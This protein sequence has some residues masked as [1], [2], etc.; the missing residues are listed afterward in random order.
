MTE[1]DT[2]IRYGNPA[3]TFYVIIPARCRASACDAIKKMGYI[4]Y[5]IT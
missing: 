4:V 1:Y 2:I 3:S 5:E